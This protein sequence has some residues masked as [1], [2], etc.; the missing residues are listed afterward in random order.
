MQL[1]FILIFGIVQRN[2]RTI[3]RPLGKLKEQALAISHGDY[4]VRINIP[5]GDEIGQLAETFNYM[6]A[7]ISEEMAGR[8]QAEDAQRH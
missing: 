5:S 1:I 6:A 3:S 2:A 8:K 4:D 7:T